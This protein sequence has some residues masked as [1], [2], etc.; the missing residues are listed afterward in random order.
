MV[1]TY[2]ERIAKYPGC[3]YEQNGKFKA[4]IRTAAHQKFKNGFKTRHEAE[5]WLKQYCI[6]NHLPIKNIIT[7]MGDH[8]SINAC[9][10]SFLIDKADLPLVEQHIFS[11]NVNNTQKYVKTMINGHYTS[12]HKLLLPTD[13]PLLT[14]DHI[15]I[16][17]LNNRRGNLRLTNR[18][19]QNMNKNI[20]K[21]NTTGHTG[22]A[23]IENSWKA[24]WFENHVRKL[25]FSII[26]IFS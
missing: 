3:I 6:D 7:D 19:V 20:Q 4:S 22:I 21:N 9:T 17:G 2:P 16:N 14:V 18:T 23:K 1:T 25:I 15:D 13:N 24:M 12:L 5:V 8:Y 26:Y 10:D 11:A